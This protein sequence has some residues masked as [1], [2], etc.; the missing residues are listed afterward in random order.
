MITASQILQATDQR[1]V[2]LGVES[3]K[4]MTGGKVNSKLVCAGRRLMTLKKA[5]LNIGLTE[6][7]KESILYCMLRLSGKFDQPK[8]TKTGGLNLNLFPA[9]LQLFDVGLGDDIA[10]YWGIG[11]DVSGYL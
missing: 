11:L 6:D 2:E 4:N 8:N 5:Y 9:P 7:E 1:I 10:D 3:S